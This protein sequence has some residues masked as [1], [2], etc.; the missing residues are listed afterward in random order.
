MAKI[1]LTYKLKPGVSADEFETWVRTT[2][3][4]AMRGLSRVASFANHRV[5][6]LLLGEG[7]PGMDYI[8]VFDVPDINGFMTQDMPGGVVQG[9]MGEFMSK[10]DDPKFILADEVV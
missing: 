2:D 1:I 3:Y 7:E 4:P 9:I 6:G 8:E 10:V 5:T